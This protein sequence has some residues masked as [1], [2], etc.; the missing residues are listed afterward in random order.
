MKFMRD[1]LIDR[2]GSFGRIGKLWLIVLTLNSYGQSTLVDDTTKVL[3]SSGSTFFFT[4][5]QLFYNLEKARNPD[6]T[7]F[8]RHDYE[9]RWIGS[10]SMQLVSNY[11]GPS[12]TLT[13]LLPEHIGRRAGWDAFEPYRL[14]AREIHYY[15]TRSPYSYVDYVQGGLGQQKLEAF[16]T[17]NIKPNWNTGFSI[18]RYASKKVLGRINQADRESDIYSG[19]AFTRYTSKTKRYHLLAAWTIMQAA[20]FGSGGIVPDSGNTYTDLFDYSLENVNLY[21]SRTYDKQNQI[22]LYQQYDL[23]GNELQVFVDADARIRLNRYSD[24]ASDDQFTYYPEI[25]YDSNL[26]E[27]RTN[28]QWVDTRAGIKGSKG[29]L[30]YASWLKGRY[31]RWEN[32]AHSTDSA[33]FFQ[34]QEWHIGAE[35]QYEITD[36]LPL[37]LSASHWLGQDYELKARLGTWRYGAQARRLSYTPELLMQNY[38]SNHYRWQLDDQSVGAAELNLWYRH[39]FNE[40]WLVAFD[41]SAQQWRNPVIMGSQGTPQRISGNS[42][43]YKGVIHLGWRTRM[44]GIETLWSFQQSTNTAVFQ[45]PVFNQRTSLYIK[46]YLFKKASFIIAGFDIYSRS[47]VYGAYWNPVAARFFLNDES[48]PLASL[49]GYFSVD[50]FA[51]MQVR[52]AF[53]FAKFNFLNEGL[54]FT[55]SPGYM[56]TPYYSALPRTFTFGVKWQFFD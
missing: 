14:D 3:Y 18:N 24:K 7:V 10:Q 26:T 11:A 29:R 51:N 16:F 53:L 33:I 37:N 41:G 15:D 52:Q 20:H 44:T 38:L 4:E 8:R 45:V 36:S 21:S 23:K 47:Q 5:A 30:F 55:G 48:D 19:S 27:D 28:H 17:V 42:S 43:V 40:R 35:G 49:R 46:E 22:Y 2:I 50:V 39:W 13:P 54:A 56:E 34:T 9:K 1:I 31:I 6:T 25:R 32:T 12:Q